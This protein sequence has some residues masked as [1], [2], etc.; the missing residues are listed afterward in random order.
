MPVRESAS[1]CVNDGRCFI[2]DD[3][4]GIAEDLRAAVLERGDRLDRKGE[5]AG[6]GLAIVQEVLEAYGRSL[7]LETSD[8]GGLIATF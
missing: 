4:P 8:L 3:G 7:T 2:E 5:G 6:L 1:A